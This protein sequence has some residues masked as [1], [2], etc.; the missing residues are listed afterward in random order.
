MTMRTTTRSPLMSVLAREKL[1][2]CSAP[3]RVSRGL[4]FHVDWPA[5]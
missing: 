2:D 1:S 5:V 4:E 3:S